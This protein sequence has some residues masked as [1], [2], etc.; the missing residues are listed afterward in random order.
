MVNYREKKYA[1]NRRNGLIA[2]ERVFGPRQVTPVYFEWNSLFLSEL[3]VV[4]KI[5]NLGRPSSWSSV[6][7]SPIFGFSRRTAVIELHYT[8]RICASFWPTW[9]INARRFVRGRFRRLFLKTLMAL[10]D[11]DRF[12]RTTPSDRRTMAAQVPE[13]IAKTDVYR[14]MRSQFDG[15]KASPPPH[16]P[17]D[18][19]T[20]RAEFSAS[21]CFEI[22]LS[23]Y[24]TP[25]F[26][27]VPKLGSL[28]GA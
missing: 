9:P 22:N 7:V 24:L 23:D 14:T 26:D 13:W 18:R 27:S 12:R 20:G 19:S 28:T 10:G 8:H 25:A 6:I 1:F 3:S 17:T 15:A 16:G 4:W 11:D 21:G 5:E 2:S